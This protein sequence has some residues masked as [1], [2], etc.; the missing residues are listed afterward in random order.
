MI[1]AFA[2]PISIVYHT[3]PNMVIMVMHIKNSKYK[4]KENIITDDDDR[5]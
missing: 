5:P 2:L 1:R 4:M 3:L